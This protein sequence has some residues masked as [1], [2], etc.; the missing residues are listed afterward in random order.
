MSC[1]TARHLSNAHSFSRSA[2]RPR[3]LR[4]RHTLRHT[5][6]MSQRG[7][8]PSVFLMRTIPPPPSL[9][10]PSP[11]HPSLQADPH[12]HIPVTRHRYDTKLSS[13]YGSVFVE[14]LAASKGVICTSGGG[15]TADGPVAYF[16]GER[17]GNGCCGHN[18]FPHA[19]GGGVRM[20]EFLAHEIEGTAH[21]FMCPAKADDD[22]Y[23]MPL[24]PL[25]ILHHFSGMPRSSIPAIYSSCSKIWLFG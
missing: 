21:R 10:S 14:K 2:S 11:L 20:F 23:V 1:V 6:S 12:P 5:H 18:C 9:P 22:M 7:A 15:N 3:G 17:A 24:L 8:C 19:Y 4:H 25:N 13:S 16:Y